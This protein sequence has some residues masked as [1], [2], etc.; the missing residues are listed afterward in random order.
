MSRVLCG[1]SL[2]FWGAYFPDAHRST[3]NVGNVP[4]T[5]YCL[6]S[7]RRLSD[8]EGDRLPPVFVR[9]S[10]MRPWLARR[11][12]GRWPN[13]LG[14]QVP[15]SFI[16]II[17]P[18]G[19]LK[20]ACKPSWLTLEIGDSRCPSIISGSNALSL[21]RLCRRRGT[22]CSA[23]RKPVVRTETYSVC[24]GEWIDSHFPLKSPVSRT[25]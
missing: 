2:W 18:H 1:Q 25:R 7:R 16:R 11:A 12:D 19:A 22:A 21:C 13:C 4:P 14:N 5:F 24:P 23:W 8:K 9:V 20:A 6:G 3:E 17:Y 10:G 15:E